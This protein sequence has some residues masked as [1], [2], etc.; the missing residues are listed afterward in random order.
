MGL[1]FRVWGLGFR[2]QGPGSRVYLGGLAVPFWE[3]RVYTRLRRQHL[4]LLRVAQE[5]PRRGFEHP[6]IKQV[7]RYKKT[8]DLILRMCL[9]QGLAYIHSRYRLWGS[10][11]SLVRTALLVADFILAR[12]L[13]RDDDGEYLAS[14]YLDLVQR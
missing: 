8:P 1:G 2:V 13:L 9:V 12:R 7:E 6:A 10:G 3:V 5:Y 14:L 11:A 4:V